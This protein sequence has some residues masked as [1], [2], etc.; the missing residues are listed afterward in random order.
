M[1][2]HEIGFYAVNVKISGAQLPAVVSMGQEHNVANVLK[3]MDQLYYQIS[4]VPT[5]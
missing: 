2:Q 4:L 3:A 5:V 1:P